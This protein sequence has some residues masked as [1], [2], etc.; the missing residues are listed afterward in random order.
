MRGH[1]V[2]IFNEVFYIPYVLLPPKGRKNWSF[3]ANKFA[4]EVYPDLDTSYPPPTPAEIYATGMMII[5]F[6]GGPDQA[7]E[8]LWDVPT[9]Y[10]C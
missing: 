2:M 7:T 8:F 10:S 3:L 1:E 5:L 4:L 9:P 6:T